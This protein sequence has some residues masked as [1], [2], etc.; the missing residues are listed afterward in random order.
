[1]LEMPGSRSVSELSYVI[2]RPDK[3]PD[4]HSLLYESFHL[5]EP[6]TSHLQL[7]QV[8]NIFIKIKTS[9]QEID[10]IENDSWKY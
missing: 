10:R 7:C 3:L 2:V 6:M 1:M 9:N 5:D 4:V 8:R